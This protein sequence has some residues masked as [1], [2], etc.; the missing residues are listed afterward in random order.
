M[1]RYLRFEVVPIEEITPDILKYWDEKHAHVQR[2]SGHW[3][4]VSS[5]RMKTFGRAAW[6]STGLKCVS[7]GIKGKFFAVEQSPGQES[8][9]LN[10]YGVN[11]DG[12]EVL[13]T[14]DHIIARALGG[15]DNLSNAQV[16]CS[17]CNHKKGLIEGKEAARRRKLAEKEKNAKIDDQV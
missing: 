10:L 14:H 11:D 17:P 3:V 2:P 6:S 16:M 4:G 13:F 1:Q 12:E 5:L 8:H 9:H 7:C 15:A